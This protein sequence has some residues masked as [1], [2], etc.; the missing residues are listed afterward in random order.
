MLKNMAP[1]QA[2]RFNTRVRRAGCSSV[3]VTCFHLEPTFAKMGHRVLLLLLALLY[4]ARS[5]GT[6][7]L[8][9]DANAA[10]QRL[11]NSN[12]A[13]QQGGCRP[14][15]KNCA[16]AVASRMF[17]DACNKGV[18]IK[19]R[20]HLQV[21]LSINSYYLASENMKSWA[22]NE[23]TKLFGP[24]ENYDTMAG[25]VFGLVRNVDQQSQRTAQQNHILQRRAEE[26]LDSGPDGQ[27][28]P[29]DVLTA[30]NLK[31]HVSEAPRH[32]CNR[33]HYLKDFD[34]SS[35]F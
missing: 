9:G 14:D 24:D 22:S 28:C 5:F 30:P 21:I 26:G 18:A 10:T 11:Y 8:A 35:S 20:I 4:V 33:D 25:V 2:E 31:I 23:C 27:N 32:T 16:L 6:L 13:D 7:I 15:P 1:W 19:D 17:Q 34:E 29:P 12:R 3:V